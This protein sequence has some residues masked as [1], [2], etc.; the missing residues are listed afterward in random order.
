MAVWLAG[1]LTKTDLDSSIGARIGLLCLG[2][3][4]GYLQMHSKTLVESSPLLQSI[5]YNVLG[6]NKCSNLISG[7]I[8]E[9]G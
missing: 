8:T 5:P 1:R 9:P 7:I 6:V 4:V 3:K 2:I